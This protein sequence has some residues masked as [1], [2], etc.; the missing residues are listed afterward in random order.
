M[1]PISLEI[2]KRQSELIK[3]LEMVYIIEK[4][5]DKCYINNIHLPNSVF[6]HV[7]KEM[8]ATALGF[9]AH[10][11]S[12]FA[13][14]V[15]VPLRY[16]IIPRSSRSIIIDRVSHNGDGLYTDSGSKME[17]PLFAKNQERVRFEYAV[18]LLN[19]DIEQVCT[20]DKADEQFWVASQEL[21]QHVTQLDGSYAATST[22]VFKTV[23]G[24]GGRDGDSF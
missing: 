13:E 7:D 8:V 6:N 21:A 24:F 16:P 18:F 20:T 15:N 4:K 9:A 23:Y 11:V 10:Y 3:D 22:F 14:Y 17:F 2:L 12:I 19:K 5:S 1:R